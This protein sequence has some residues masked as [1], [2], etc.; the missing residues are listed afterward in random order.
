MKSVLNR[1]SR[2]ISILVIIM[3]AS[4]PV[5]AQQEISGS[6]YSSDNLEPLIGA[7]IFVKESQMGVVT[8]IDGNFRLTASPEDVLMISY[9]GFKSKEIPVGNNTQLNIS[10]DLDMS[11]LNEVIVMGY[12]SKSQKELS[13]SVVTIKADKLQSVTSSNIQTMLQGQAAGVTVSS[14][15]GA[16][17][18]TA[19]IRIRGITSINNDKPPLIVVDGIIGGNYVPN[20]V[21]TLTVLK[22]AAAIG[23]YGSSGAAGVIIITTKSGSGQP[24]MSFSSSVGIK[25]VVTGN[26][27]MMNGA[28]L[29]DAQRD[30]WGESNL[31]SFLNN[32][33]EYLEDR[34]FNWLDA[35]FD[36]AL[37]QNYSLAMSGSTKGVSYGFSMDYF[38]EDG[39]FI[40][41][42]YERLNLRGN[43]KFDITDKLRVQTDIN[44]Q[45]SRNN[46]HHYSWFEDAFWN[47]P[48]DNPYSA[49]GELY[50]PRYVTSNSNEWIGQFR[51]S[52]LYSAEYD[53]LKY[54]DNSLV[55]STSFTYDITSWLSLETRTRL[56]RY[57][58]QTNEYYS[59]LTDFGLAFNGVVTQNRSEGQGVLSTHFLRFNKSFGKHDLGGFIAHE[60][61][62]YQENN[63]SFGGRNLSSQTVKVPS[64]ASMINE[65]SGTNVEDRGI[66]YIGEANYGFDTKYFATAYFRRDGSSRFAENKQFGNFYGGSLAWLMSEE[67]FLN[68][69]SA[70]DQLKLR[71]SY[72]TMGNS[73][74]ARFLSLPT[75]NITRQ[76]NGQPGGEPNNPANPNL[77]WESTEMI[78]AGIDLS[79]FNDLTINLDVYQKL[80]EGMLLDNPLPFSSGYER[81][82]ENIGDMRNR[83]LEM[84]LSYD[85][86][87]G[88]FRYSGNF[89]IS[90]N[91]NE[92]LKITDILDE[93]PQIGGN[94]QQLNKV[95]EE[96][97][98]WYMP[99][100]LGVDTETGGPMWEVISK[101]TNGNETRSVTNNYNEATFQPI[102]SA[103]P[104]YTGGFRNSLSYKDLT[105]TFLFT[106]QGGN[107]IYHETRFFVDSDG[108]NTGINLMKP[109]DDWVRW[110][111]PGDVATHPQYKR[112]GNNGAHQHSSR[113]IEKGDYIR[114]RNVSLSYNIPSNL[115]DVVNIK[116]ATLSLRADNLMTWTNF[117]GMDPDIGLNKQA[118][119]LPG[120][121]S[122][123]YP[124][125]R[126][127]LVGLNVNF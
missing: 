34:N 24:S 116:S 108:A 79:I 80:V 95:G 46:F 75:Y 37:I 56:S 27:E 12:S 121:S 31:V 3:I 11:E 42:D 97:F 10:L 82:T 124:I 126:Q 1:L 62:I 63:L 100:W 73:D 90:F 125:S 13:A 65:W 101:D 51:R 86:V 4:I 68:S 111:K 93:Q 57:T 119:A 96:A 74:I 115:L 78:N 9:V 52:F 87:F 94:L 107:H 104:E 99:K 28:E 30:M 39:T 118:Y 35:A 106:F 47:M 112:G 76:Y 55:W 92:I 6:V 66:S 117:S 83:G 48:W 54:A 18:A 36:K 77:G 25:E 114:L 44:T 89:N 102:A 81:R 98:M 45:W 21:E 70:I 113:Y 69:I 49:D 91:K 23:L 127:F 19:D 43:L 105:L 72:G 20:D 2:G 22:D 32:R 84:A 61:G 120:V 41:T 58:G 88:N 71:A 8:D 33:P 5:K 103:L 123:K 59:P 64:G 50:G 109:Q 122:L 53:E 15:S 38:N 60:G 16:P 17:G 110:E 7:T 40:K 14:S 29:Y 26:F 67:S 85:K